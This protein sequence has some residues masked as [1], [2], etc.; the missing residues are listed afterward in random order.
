MV[1]R[2]LMGDNDGED[3]GKV[4]LLFFEGAFEE[5]EIL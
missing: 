3:E 1:T 2:E 4:N 5:K